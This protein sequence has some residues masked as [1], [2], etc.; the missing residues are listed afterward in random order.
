MSTKKETANAAPN[1][2]VKTEYFPGKPRKMGVESDVLT[3]G[4]GAANHRRV[5]PAVWRQTA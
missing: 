3:G 4:S 1:P 2:E 5:F